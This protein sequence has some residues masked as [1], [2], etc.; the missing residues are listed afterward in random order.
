MRELKVR[1]RRVD[2]GKWVYGYLV[3]ETK[4]N[5]KTHYIHH[6]CPPG[7]KHVSTVIPESVGRYVFDDKNDKPVFAGD[8]ILAGKT[9]KSDGILTFDEIEL[10]WC[11]EEEDG[12]LM[13]IARHWELDEIE[14]VTK[15]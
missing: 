9:T 3:V 7:M 1:G 2:N 5:S 15:D 11:L 10:A 4:G 13:T 8:R 12:N 14:T 6:E